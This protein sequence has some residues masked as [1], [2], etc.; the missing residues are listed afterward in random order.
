MSSRRKGIPC[1]ELIFVPEVLAPSAAA[2]AGRNSWF[3]GMIYLTFLHRRREKRD[4]TDS[5]GQSIP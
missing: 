5:Q 4:D 2:F 1:R 3:F